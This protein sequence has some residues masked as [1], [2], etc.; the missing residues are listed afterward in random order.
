MTQAGTRPILK[1]G[2]GQLVYFRV[3][4]LKF[5]ILFLPQSRCVNAETC[6]LMPWGNFGAGREVGVA[7]CVNPLKTTSSSGYEENCIN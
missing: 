1:G 5:Y 6:E 4:F 3:M 2:K 7:G